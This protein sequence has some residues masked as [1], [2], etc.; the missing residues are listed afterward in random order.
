[1]GEM[2]GEMEMNPGGQR[3]H[4][5]YQSPDVTSRI[6]LF[7]M[8]VS[9]RQSSNFQKMAGIDDVFCE[10]LYASARTHAPH[11]SILRRAALRTALGRLYEAESDLSRAVEVHNQT[12]IPVE[13]IRVAQWVSERIEFVLRRTNLRRILYYI[14]INLD[15]G[16]Y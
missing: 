5:S 7:E 8:G 1:M 10:A 14:P 16:G 4:E 2:L 15:E 9:K 13:T 3:E 6:T 11:V 12:G